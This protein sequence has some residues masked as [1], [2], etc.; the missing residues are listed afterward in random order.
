[1]S[2]CFKYLAAALLVGGMTPM[3]LASDFATLSG[4]TSPVLAEDGMEHDFIFTFTNTSTFNISMINP[5][6]P[7]VLPTVSD[8]DS[9]DALT[10]LTWGAG[11]A[12]PC[13]ASLTGGASCTLQLGLTAGN[14]SGD[15]D[16][17]FG[18][19]L[20][21]LVLNF[22]VARP[23]ISQFAFTDDQITDAMSIT[24]NDVSPTTTVPEP[25]TL[26]LLGV[27]LGGIGFARRRA[28][29]LH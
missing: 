11:G 10:A 29:A 20:M 27:G 26:A 13:G 1:M 28:R 17:D 4:N 18:T 19:S 24:V 8:G 21:D 12:D 22:R 5:S 2:R 7:G 6:P 25:A 23:D 14:G 3:A 15:V 16:L 9:N